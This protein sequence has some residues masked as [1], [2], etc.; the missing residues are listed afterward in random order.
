MN[1]E[2]V[3]MR[4][5]ISAILAAFFITGFIALC[6]TV[7]SANALVNKNSVPVSNSPQATAAASTTNDPPATTAAQTEIQQLEARINQYQQREQQYQKREQQ[8]Q[9]QLQ[10]AQQ[11][12]QTANS[13]ISQFQQLL[14]V[15]QQRG[16]IF[17]DQNG[18]IFLP[19]R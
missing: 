18:R 5:Q 17:I 11:Q 12:I 15:L 13:Q 3:F 2:K 19:G 16:L 6:M 14:Q 1:M 10:T 9:Q 7:V 4:K 8:Y